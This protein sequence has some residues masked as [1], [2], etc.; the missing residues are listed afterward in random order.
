[1][2]APTAAAASRAP[3]ATKGAVTSR[4]CFCRVTSH[5]AAEGH[6][7]QVACGSLARAERGAVLVVLGQHDLNLLGLGQRLDHTRGAGQP[8]GAG[9]GEAAL[10]GGQEVG[11]V[12]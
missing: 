12:L 3:R 10:T 7:A 8:S 6:K 9:C 2:E 11:S 4:G 1:M 5:S